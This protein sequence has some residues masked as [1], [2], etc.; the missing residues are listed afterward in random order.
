MPL[1]AKSGEQE[2][3][4]FAQDRDSAGHLVRSERSLS[5]PQDRGRLGAEK[6]SRVV[7][8]A[9]VP[10][11]LK[12]E[13]AIRHVACRYPYDAED[14]APS[15]RSDSDDAAHAPEIAADMLRR[16]QAGAV[17]QALRSL[18][19]TGLVDL[20]AERKASM[21]SNLLMVLCGDQR[22]QPVVNAGT[23]YG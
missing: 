4:L 9:G 13:A 5:R 22:V 21:V 16:Q 19:E 14:G 23:L 6:W 7:D 20:D 10:L 8:G 17:E 11:V 2:G 15:L 18:E 12:A 1:P 3:V